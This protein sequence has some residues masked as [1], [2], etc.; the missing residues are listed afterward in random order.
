[1]MDEH[2]TNTFITSN[3]KIFMISVKN[4]HLVEQRST[5]YYSSVFKI[6]TKKN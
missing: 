4:V 6:N 3:Y 1:M 5:A 2:A